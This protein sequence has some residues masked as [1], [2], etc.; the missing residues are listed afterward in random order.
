MHCTVEASRVAA[1]GHVKG[2]LTCSC[3]G[4]K[5]LLRVCRSSCRGNAAKLSGST[6]ARR[7]QERGKR[8]AKDVKNRK[9]RKAQRLFQGLH[10]S[11]VS[12]LFLRYGLKPT[13]GFG[14]PGAACSS[15]WRK[16]GSEGGA[17][18][19]RD[20]VDDLMFG[21]GNALQ[22]RS[23]WAN[24][25][26]ARHPVSGL[27]PPGFDVSSTSRPWCSRLAEPGD[28]ARAAGSGFLVGSAA[29]ETLWSE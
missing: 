10:S 28:D 1:S 17:D 2:T 22:L 29:P 24:I 19:F 4:S 3:S 21:P 27:D 9:W 23:I 12:V 16:G 26:Q 15:G 5:W 25:F 20:A 18:R 14:R 11:F 7:E 13:P 8:Q 6:A